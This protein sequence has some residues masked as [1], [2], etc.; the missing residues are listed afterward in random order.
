MDASDVI[1]AET[2]AIIDTGDEEVMR[3]F[4]NTLNYAADEIDNALYELTVDYKGD[5]A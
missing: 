2:Q 4:R 1:F 3:D 5:N